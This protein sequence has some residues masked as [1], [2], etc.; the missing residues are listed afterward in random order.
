MPS[1]EISKLQAVSG[2]RAL[3]G[4]DRGTI[5]A[6]SAPTSDQSAARSDGIAIEV[7][8]AVDTASPPIDKERVQQIKEALRDG[9]YPLIPTEI[10]DA[11]IAAQLSFGE[12][13]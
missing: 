9:S 6:R 13:A 4:S 11:M 1:F 10:A 3:P 2:P 12:P 5:E 7:G 8:E